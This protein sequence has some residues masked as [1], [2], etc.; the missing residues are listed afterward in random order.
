MAII[1][2]RECAL[3]DRGRPSADGWG[4]CKSVQIDPINFVIHFPLPISFPTSSSSCPVI[5]LGRKGRR[6][7]CDRVTVSE[8]EQWR[9]LAPEFL[10]GHLFYRTKREFVYLSPPPPTWPVYTH[11][12]GGGRWV[13]LVFVIIINWG[14]GGPIYDSQTLLLWIISV[15]GLSK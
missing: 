4:T 10:S 14:R 2:S 7:G 11:A 9:K 13:A 15:V 8:K 1:I 5:K 6:R 3:K 12:G